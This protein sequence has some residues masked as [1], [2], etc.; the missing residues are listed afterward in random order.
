MPE[1]ESMEDREVYWLEEIGQEYND[2]VG[3]KSANLG[4]ALKVA[5]IQ[6]SPGFAISIGAYKK[7]INKTS[8]AREI[9][10]YLRQNVP[11]GRNMVRRDAGA[12]APFPA[13]DHW[14]TDAAFVQIALQRPQGGRR[15]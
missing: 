4:E 9:R 5:G 3:K 8:I 11:K 7:F 14:N 15:C 10:Q 1:R 12:G 2:I 6:S 13:R